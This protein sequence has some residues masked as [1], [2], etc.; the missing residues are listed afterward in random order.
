[1]FLGRIAPT[2]SGF[3]CEGSTLTIECPPGQKIQV[4]RANYGR[5]N[6]DVCNDG[7]DTE[8]WNLQCMSTRAPRIVNDLYVNK[9]DVNMF[10]NF[11]F[12]CSA[13]IFYISISYTIL[14]GISISQFYL[15]MIFSMSF[16]FVWH[17]VS[18][19]IFVFGCI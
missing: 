8:S 7:R 13:V 9:F 14:F 15:V 11:G 10:I 4:V 19:L 16:N 17:Y 3:A 6:R 18:T 12:L 1:M 5:F 2:L